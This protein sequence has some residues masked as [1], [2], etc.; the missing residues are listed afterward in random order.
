MKKISEMTP[1][2]ALTE[3][4]LAV[5]KR[6]LEQARKKAGESAAATK[7]VFDALEDMCIEPDEIPSAAENAENLEEAICCFIDYGEYSVSGIMREVRAAYK[8]AEE[9]ITALRTIRR[10]TTEQRLLCSSGSP[11]RT[12]RRIPRRR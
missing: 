5:F 7:A 8:E 1:D 3:Q 11:R 6:R 9:C 12:R 4:A 2:E 10:R